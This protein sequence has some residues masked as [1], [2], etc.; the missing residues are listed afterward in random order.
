MKRRDLERLL[1][2]VGC[3]KKLPD[4]GPHTKWICPCGRHSVPVP[5]HREISPGVVDD[6]VAKLL[7]LPEGWNA[8]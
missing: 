7:C 1:R 6:V 5:R 2:A 3:S 8:K 4:K